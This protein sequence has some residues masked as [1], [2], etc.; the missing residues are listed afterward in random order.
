MKFNF[1]T[2]TVIKYRLTHRKGLGWRT[3]GE[4]TLLMKGLRT[5]ILGERGVFKNRTIR[6]LKMYKNT[7]NIY[8]VYICKNHIHM[9]L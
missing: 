6:E 9:Y 8:N 4:K 3:K 1:F 5:Q 7:T 2:K